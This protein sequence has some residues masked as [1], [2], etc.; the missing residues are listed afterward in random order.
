MKK[1]ICLLLV[2]VSLLMLSS[3]ALANYDDYKPKT[4]EAYKAELNMKSNEEWKGSGFNR[5]LLSFLVYYDFKQNNPSVKDEYVLRY[6][7][8]WKDDGTNAYIVIAD[9]NT[10]IL[11]LDYHLKTDLVSVVDV[12]K[13]GYLMTTKNVHDFYMS[14]SNKNAKQSWELSNSDMKEALKYIGEVERE[15]K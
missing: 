1:I 5:S 14:G 6:L 3:S 15:K 11:V 9:N 13:D 8:R 7:I 12:T 2:A 4:V 10:S